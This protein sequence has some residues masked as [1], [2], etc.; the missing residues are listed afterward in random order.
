MRIQCMLSR[1]WPAL[2]A[3]IG[4][5]LIP[6][7]AGLRGQQ[8]S[9]PTGRTFGPA[10]LTAS[11]AQ[12]QVMSFTDSFVGTA[13]EQWTQVERAALIASGPPA[14]GERD[15]EQ[16]ARAAHEIKLANVGAAVSIAASANPIVAAADIIT[17]ITLQRRAL[18]DPWASELF[19]PQLARSLADAYRDE[20]AAARRIGA[21][22]FTS[23]QER[24]LLALIDAWREKHPDRHFV[25]GVRM[26]DFGRER[27]QVMVDSAGGPGG[28]FALVDLDSATLEVER[29]RLLGERMFFYAEHLPTLTR[30][31]AESVYLGFLG[32]AQAKKAL[33]AIAGASEAAAAVA[34]A[35][36]RL[37]ADLSAE[38]TAALNQLFGGLT[39][40]R[41]QTL[42]EI[43]QGQANLQGSLKELREAV[44]AT[45]ALSLNL[46]QT[47]KAAD[48]VAARF[49][50]VPG[51]E[52]GKDRD[53]WAEY[54][55]A[56]AQTAQTAEQLTILTQRIASVLESPALNGT[57][58]GVQGTVASVQQSAQLVVDHA[59]WRVLILL[60]LAPFVV[61]ISL[62]VMRWVGSKWLP[63]AGRV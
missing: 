48:V 42:K 7:C 61:G 8:G 4:C 15:A 12:S 21:G 37:P 39:E 58:A 20:E 28:L 45:D 10:N 24:E 62:G 25:S 47:L 17:M 32:S 23:E 53:V 59:F 3:L 19:G 16:A 40:Q 60:C 27:Q 54:R 31:Q 44:Q 63:R 50:A 13:T 11:A 49:A 43:D 30:W 22:V 55:S 56:A 6:G 2:V 29:S 9:G 41:T 38:R 18:E 35:A 1:V 14:P 51:S 34:A 57:S 33:A 52:A 36:D 26:E 46:T 5:V